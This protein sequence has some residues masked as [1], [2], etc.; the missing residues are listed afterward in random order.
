MPAETPDNFSK[1]SLAGGFRSAL[2]AQPEPDPGAWPSQ[3]RVRTIQWTTGDLVGGR[4][5]KS[6][7]RFLADTI[8]VIGSCIWTWVRLVG[9]PGRWVVDDG[10]ESTRTAAERILEDLSRRL[11]TDRWQSRRGTGALVT[12]LATMLFRDGLFGGFVLLSADGTEIDR[13]AVI[14]PARIGLSEAGG[15]PDR[16]VY[17]TSRSQLNLQRPDFFYSSLGDSYTHPLG[18][19]ILQAVPFVSYIEQQLVDDMR[20]ASHNA[21]FHRL[22]VKITPPERMGGESDTAYTDRVNQYFDATVEMVRGCDVDDNPV[23]WDNVSLDHIGPAKSRDVTN[24]WFI[25]GA[26]TTWSDFKFDIVMRQVQSVQQ[27]LSSFLERMGQIELVLKGHTATCR[28]EFD[29]T[30]TYQIADRI[31]SRSVEVDSLLKLYEAGLIDRD[32][33]ARQACRLI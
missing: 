13:F 20:R 30:L 24:S 31:Q 22:H 15:L 10:S 19:S 26:T 27:Q 33:A 25:Y 21:G 17:E 5:Q 1:R 32:T 14:D 11:Y 28:Y 12:D 6:L 8:P 7:Y 16:L 23:T 29:N 4:F 2:I 9:A 3:S 18:R